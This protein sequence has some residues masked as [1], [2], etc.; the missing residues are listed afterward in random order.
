MHVSC[1]PGGAIQADTKSRG[2]I[3]HV[4]F[5]NNQAKI[6][7]G[8]PSATPHQQHVVAYRRPRCVQLCPAASILTHSGGPCA[9]AID[10]WGVIVS[11]HSTFRYNRAQYG[12]AVSCCKGDRGGGGVH[13]ISESGFQYNTAVEDGGGAIFVLKGALRLD[14]TTLLG[15]RAA[16]TG[17]AILGEKGSLDVRQTT[18]DANGASSG[19]SAVWVVGVEHWLLDSSAIT[20][21]DAKSSVQ[22]FSS[23][24]PTCDS[25]PCNTGM[26]CLYSRSSRTCA[27]CPNGT[28]SRTGK[29]CSPCEKGL[30][31]TG[32]KKS[33]KGCED[34]TYSPLGVGCVSCKNVGTYSNN[35]TKEMI[36][37]SLNGVTTSLRVHQ[38][39]PK[40]EWP[41][42]ANQNHTKCECPET[43]FSLN[44]PGWTDTKCYS[45][46]F[47][48]TQLSV[49]CPGGPVGNAPILADK[50]V[51]IDA[52]AFMQTSAEWHTCMKK[53]ASA[54]ALTVSQIVGCAQFKDSRPS[55][56]DELYLCDKKLCVG[57][58]RNADS[59]GKA[60]GLRRL[61]AA[62]VSLTRT[63]FTCSVAHTQGGKQIQNCCGNG[64]KHGSVLCGVC[65]ANFGKVEGKGPSSPFRASV[66]A[67]RALNATGQSRVTLSL[68]PEHLRAAC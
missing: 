47:A 52:E 17:G 49:S 34:G 55:P 48:N 7:G 42:V 64:V 33:C 16:A 24:P 29:A 5:E 11:K 38:S 54:N 30:M 51:F 53:K 58:Q 35:D 4:T 9:G 19:G 31:P 60:N 32:D 63:A 28:A 67:A 44:G 12:G 39:C 62:S 13:N 3:T 20:P 41:T 68:R 56:A 66:C 45:C 14:K 26:E 36:R 2:M 21:F 22:Y 15:N 50:G 8:A 61:Q 27:S 25:N 57:T 37:L 59:N 18:F 40:C 1:A 65:D 43:F 6:L 46:V 10:S 23:P